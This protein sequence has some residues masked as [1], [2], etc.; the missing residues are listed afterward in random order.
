MKRYVKLI[1]TLM[2][3][4][5]ITVV[6]FTG[7]NKSSK[8]NSDKV[9]LK[10]LLSGA[11]KQ[12]D[13]DKVWALFNEK[14]QNYL[15]D[16]NVEFENIPM[17][18]YGEKWKLIA[19][20]GEQFDIAWNGSWITPFQEE[21]Q[22]GSYL[23]LNDLL[24]KYA[25]ELKASMPESIWKKNTVNNKIYAIPNNQVAITWRPT[26]A[27]GYFLTDKYNF[28]VEE[29]SKLAQSKETM[30]K[31]V[32]A[33]V[34]K[35]LSKV[36]AGGDLG[37]GICPPFNTVEKGYE[38]VT[39][40]YKLK[41]Y[42]SDYQVNNLYEVP[43]YKLYID[44]VAD[45]YKKGYIRQD[46]LTG[47]SADLTKIQADVS[48]GGYAVKEGTHRQLTPTQEDL[49]VMK[50]ENYSK[51]RPYNTAILDKEPVI[52]SSAWATST[53]ILRT[54]KQPETAM[55]LLSLI[56]SAKGRE[57]YDLLVWG[58]E[59]EHYKVI[60][61]N[62]I[63]PTDYRGTPT[64]DS[65]YG[66]QRWI[67]GN[68]FNSFEMNTDPPNFIK[69]SQQ[70][71]ATAKGSRI[72]GFNLDTTPIKS[73]LEQVR[74][75]LGQYVKPLNSGALS[76]YQDKYNEFLQKLKLAGN[77]KI[78]AEITRQIEEWAKTNKK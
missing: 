4:C 60:G 49:D 50:A 15:P 67:V 44:T 41:I 40:P 23:P 6:G 37:L 30:T 31:E 53:A 27:F 66:I 48:N 24:D 16:V 35:F 11:G 62:R 5:M 36:K 57:L 75:V 18:D 73:E 10:W 69:N 9:T 1:S 76:D 52:D 17:S 56:N 22:K 33:E 74:A 46:I 54:C 13:S 77:E 3:V 63:Q 32:Y 64:S 55:K 38:S 20:S 58:I 14:L 78:K 71:N 70:E 39:Q 19:A 12:L 68:V 21:V 42:G 34:E 61:D 25:P 28:N 26:I 72:L 45:W 7:C 29:F 47:M 2:A 43:E 8:A 65:K 51:T 59:A